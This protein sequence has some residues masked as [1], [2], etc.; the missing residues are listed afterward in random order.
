MWF[1]LSEA[2]PPIG[3]NTLFP[4]LEF[5]RNGPKNCRLVRPRVAKSTPQRGQNAHPNFEGGFRNCCRETPPISPNFNRALCWNCPK[6][7]P[8]FCKANSANGR[9]AELTKRKGGNGGRK[10]R[11]KLHIKIMKFKIENI[12]NLMFLFLS[13]VTSF[14]LCGIRFSRSSPRLRLSPLTQNLGSLL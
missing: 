14:P 5:M 10:D 2:K 4:S 7:R 1:A 12:I 3:P 6:R 13:S 11:E 9:P 8:A